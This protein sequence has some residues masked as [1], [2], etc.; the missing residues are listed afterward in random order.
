M[1]MWWLSGKV[2][3]MTAACNVAVPG[4]IPVSPTVTQSH[5]GCSKN[6][7]SLDVRRLFLSIKK[8]IV[9]HVGILYCIVLYTVQYF[10]NCCTHDLFHAAIYRA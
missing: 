1:W 3:W 6:E 9:R 10:A 8:K 5:E 4:S 2:H 7:K